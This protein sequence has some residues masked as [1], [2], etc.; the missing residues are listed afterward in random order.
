ML[1][2]TIVSTLAGIPHIDIGHHYDI[3]CQ[4]N[5]QHILCP[6]QQDCYD[7]NPTTNTQSRYKHKYPDYNNSESKRS[8]QYSKIVIET[9]AIS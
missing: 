9:M 6:L 1:F 2:S 3:F 4:I 8:D 5:N 7:I